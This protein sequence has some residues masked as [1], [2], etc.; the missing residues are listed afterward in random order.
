MR[1]VLRL[2][3][4]R[5]M[6]PHSLDTPAFGPKIS[7]QKSVI[8]RAARSHFRGKGGQRLWQEHRPK[9]HDRSSATARWPLPRRPSAGLDPITS[10]QL[11]DL[12]VN[13]RDG[14]EATIVMVSHSRRRPK[15]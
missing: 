1:W 6:T 3:G 11:D 15:R 4:R 2:V 9:I 13:L 8:R 10:S 7:Q 12:I 5:G 14:L